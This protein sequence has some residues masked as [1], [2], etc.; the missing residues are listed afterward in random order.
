MIQTL[1]AIK[2][3][4][5]LQMGVGVTYGDKA[6]IDEEI[7]RIWFRLYHTELWNGLAQWYWN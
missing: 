6:L 1:S 7:D 3:H 2:S 4:P 5:I